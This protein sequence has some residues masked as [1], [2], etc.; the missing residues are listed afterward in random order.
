M[1]YPWLEDVHRS[2]NM[3][4]ESGRFHHAHLFTGA[5]GVGKTALAEYLSGALLCQKPRG[6][7][8]C[9]DCKAC[10]LVRAQTHP[11]KLVIGREGENI[12]IDEIRTITDFIHHSAAQGGNKVVVI[13]GADRMSVAAA[14]AL[15]KT[16]EEPNARRYLFL[17]GQSKAALPATILSRCAKTDIDV[18]HDHGVAAWLS[19]NAA[20]ALRYEWADLFAS[21]PLL[22]YKWQQTQQ[23]A[24]INALAEMANKIQV[25]YNFKN[26]I[27]ILTQNSEYIAIFT[28]FIARY[29]QGLVNRG[30]DAERYERCI[31]AVY[32]FNQ[33]VRSVPGLNLGLAVTQLIYLLQQELD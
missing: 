13:Q 26:L 6:L 22:L 19:Q 32:A 31:K 9:G 23:L 33:N 16:L 2:L 5:N 7:N 29:L 30:L 24:E 27:N 20:E 3:S 17:L 11:D 1:L 21:Q 8:A 12:G 28:L 10:S 15:L 18:T 4:F 14:N 25:T